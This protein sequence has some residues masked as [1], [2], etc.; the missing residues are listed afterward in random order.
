[1]NNCVFVNH[2]TLDSDKAK[3]CLKHLFSKQTESISW[4]NFII[5]NTHKEEVPNELLLDYIKKYDVNI[6]YLF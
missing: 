1:M 4:D 2:A 3:Y 6:E 5:Y